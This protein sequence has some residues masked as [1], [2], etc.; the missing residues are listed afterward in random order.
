MRKI[1]SDEEIIAVLDEMHASFPGNKIK[2]ADLLEELNKR[3]YSMDRSTISKNAAV[4]KHLDKL[5]SESIC[6]NDIKAI[7]FNP[8]NIHSLA[9][10]NKKQIIDIVTQREVYYSECAKKASEAKKKAEE[11]QKQLNEALSG[12][13]G[14]KD[15]IIK[16]LDKENQAL[17]AVINK[18]FLPEVAND[19]IGA[20]MTK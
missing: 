15:E 16:Q 4:K 6:L 3:G 2:Q 12:V 9:N 14:P 7:V 13:E 5:N 1:V 10:M 18:H 20:E 17:K 19:L 11:L 8:I